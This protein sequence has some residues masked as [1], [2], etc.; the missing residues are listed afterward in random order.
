MKVINQ[1]YNNILFRFDIGEEVINT[2]STY[3]LENTVKAASFSALG[4]CGEITLAYYNLE[5]KHYE[6]HTFNEDLEILNLTGNVAVMEDKYIIHC[7]GVFG[8]NDCSVIGGH[9]KT[10]TVSATC[11]LIMTKLEGKIERAHDKKTGLNLLH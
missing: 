11:E 5:T 3:C 1:S 10:L 2:L 9:V 7:H 8:R 6:D 4:A